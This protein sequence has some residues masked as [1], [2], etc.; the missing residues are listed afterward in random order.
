[1]MISLL[2]HFHG[3]GGGSALIAQQNTLLALQIAS[4]GIPAYQVGGSTARARA[5]QGLSINEAL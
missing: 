5:R 2:S 4:F 3:H 1:M